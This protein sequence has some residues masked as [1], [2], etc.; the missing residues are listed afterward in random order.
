MRFHVFPK[1]T[2]APGMP[3]EGRD[4]LPAEVHANR[5]EEFSSGKSE[6]HLRDRRPEEFY[7]W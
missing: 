2:S 6:T 3:I 5:P 4:A 1:A 7:F